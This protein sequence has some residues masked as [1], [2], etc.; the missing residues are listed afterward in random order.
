MRE[1]KGIAQAASAARS[2]PLPSWES[3]EPDNGSGEEDQAWVTTY[4]DTLTLL[5]TLFVMLLAFANY[6]PKTYEQVTSALSE[7]AGGGVA[8]KAGSG[9]QTPAVGKRDDGDDSKAIAEGLSRALA[10]NGMGEGASVTVEKGRVTLALRERVL[11]SSVF[12]LVFERKSRKTGYFSCYCGD[13][14]ST[15][16]S[17]LLR[18][19]GESRCSSQRSSLHAEKLTAAGH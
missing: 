8:A 9:G 19:M 17:N 5:L 13:R 11:F 3:V 15:S 2:Q 18:I 16:S 12:K 14:M 6:D 7:E 10:E 1:G 4:I